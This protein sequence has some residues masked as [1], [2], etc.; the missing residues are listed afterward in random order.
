M[1]H[2]WAQ[3]NMRIPAVWL[4]VAVLGVIAAIIIAPFLG[5][6]HVPISAP[7]T[8]TVSLCPSSTSLSSDDVR[9]IQSS[10]QGLLSETPQL[11]PGSVRPVAG[12]CFLVTAPSAA[13]LTT[14]VALLTLPVSIA[15]TDSASYGFQP[16]TK[17]ILVCPHREPACAHGSSEGST[18]IFTRPNPRLQVVVPAQDIRPGSARIVRNQDGSSGPPILM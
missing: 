3:A 7:S 9:V 14:M 11:G 2:G 16:G 4:A 10:L 6:S 15:L 12:P 13:N 8:Q 17:V 1:P 5:Y 18:D